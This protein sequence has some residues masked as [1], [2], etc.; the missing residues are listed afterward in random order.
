MPK[1]IFFVQ[2][3]AASPEQEDEYHRWY[4]ETHIPQLCEIPGIVSA[5]RFDLVGTGAGPADPSIP[6]HA[7]I[8]EIEADDL[9]EVFAEMARRSAD[10]RTQSSDA[11]Q[12]DPP[13]VRLLY[14]ER[15]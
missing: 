5:R 11:L 13:P 6:K 7:A 9:D 15:A 1:A 3:Q 14:V 2:T 10:G 4:D 12:R 8:Y